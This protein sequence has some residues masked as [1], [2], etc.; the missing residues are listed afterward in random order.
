MGEGKDHV[1]KTIHAKRLKKS[2]TCKTCGKNHSGICWKEHLEARPDWVVMKEEFDKKK[3]DHSGDI[4]GRYEGDDTKGC[5]EGDPNEGGFG[6]LR[7]KTRRVRSV[8]TTSTTS[9]S[10]LLSGR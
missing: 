4:K 10:S 6:V 8:S 3:K 5:Y 2:E 9:S 7:S 1:K